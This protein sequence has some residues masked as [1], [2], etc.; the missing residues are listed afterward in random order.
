VNFK[1][2]LKF[3]KFEFS[4]FG[5]MRTFLNFVPE[6]F[7]GILAFSWCFRAF[8]V[9]FGSKFLVFDNILRRD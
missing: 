3:V 2:R 4:I 7:A 6:S 5:E 8:S 9:L 1:Y